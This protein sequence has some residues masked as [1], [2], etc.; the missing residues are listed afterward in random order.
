LSR[1]GTCQH[2]PRPLSVATA[3]FRPVSYRVIPKSQL[4]ERLREEFAG[5]R[6]Q[7]LVITDRGRP[8]AVLIHIERWNGLQDKIEWLEEAIELADRDLPSSTWVDLHYE[9]GPIRR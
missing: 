3:T 2:R 8:T 6:D 7:D 1:L 9:P 5:L 4:R